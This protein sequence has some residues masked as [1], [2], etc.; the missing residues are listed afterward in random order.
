MLYLMWSKEASTISSSLEYLLCQKSLALGLG[1]VR[2]Q[3]LHIKLP[4][5][6]D[7]PLLSPFLFF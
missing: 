3:L 5:V 2:Q 7:S 4:I 1:L 6:A